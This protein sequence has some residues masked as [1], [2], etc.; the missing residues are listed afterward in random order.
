MTTYCRNCGEGIEYFSKIPII[1]PFCAKPLTSQAQVKTQVDTIQA[2]VV[3]KIK[4]RKEV[5]VVESE[6]DDYEDG[7]SNENEIFDGEI[8]AP[9]EEGVSIL[10]EATKP[11]K[12]ID[13]ATAGANSNPDN[14]KIDRPQEAPMSKEQ[15]LQEFAREAGSIRKK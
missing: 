7:D 13:L 8:E 1:C 10:I 2:K 3:S 6:D 11:S 4:T 9:E 5:E 14:Y 15:I 12:L